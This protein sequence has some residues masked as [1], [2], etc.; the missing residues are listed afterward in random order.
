V[1][2]EPAGAGDAVLACY[3]ELAETLGRMTVLARGREW[4]SLP[5]LDARCS[6]I[7]ERLWALHEQGI[8]SPDPDRV[9]ALARRVRT[10]QVELQRLLAPQ[11]RHMA[12]RIGQARQPS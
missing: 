3:A 2:A 9:A 6:G 4:Q 10:D 7:F 1:S 5:S 8:A 11:F 12:R